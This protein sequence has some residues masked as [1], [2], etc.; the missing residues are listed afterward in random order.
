MS[1]LVLHDYLRQVQAGRHEPTGIAGDESRVFHAAGR[2]VRFGID[3]GERLI[4]IGSVPLFK[5]I[6]SLPGDSLMA[7]G[8]TPVSGLHEEAQ[9][10]RSHLRLIFAFKNPVA[11]ADRPGKVVNVIA[12]IGEGLGVVGVVFLVDQ[13]SARTDNFIL[14]D[15]KL[16][17]VDAEVGEE[18]GRGVILMAVP[19]SIPPDADL[20]KPLSAEYEITLPARSGL[21][22][23]KLG[24]KCNLEL[25]KCARRDGL[26]HVDVYDGLIIFITVVWGDELQLPRHVTLAYNLNVLDVF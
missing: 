3:H 14:R 4:R 11:R 24:L 25:Y 12:V 19:R 15:R 26:G 21:R 1:E 18:F 20:G 22:F 23:G 13:D 6:E 5:M 17:V 2:R 10:D 16:H 9:F 7:F 8:L